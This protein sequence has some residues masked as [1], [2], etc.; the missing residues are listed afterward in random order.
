MPVI[1]SVA[2]KPESTTKK[3]HGRGR[4]SCAL[5]GK[6]YPRV[7]RRNLVAVKKDLVMA[8]LPRGENA[9]RRVSADCEYSALSCLLLPRPLSSKTALP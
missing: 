9:P 5:L 2:R 3:E 8:G 7:R 1:T 4:G 6:H